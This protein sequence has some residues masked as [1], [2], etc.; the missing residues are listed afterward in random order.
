[1]KIDEK[2]AKTKECVNSN[3]TNM[4]LTCMG[5]Q[6]MAWKVIYHEDKDMGCC[7]KVYPNEEGYISILARNIQ[8]TR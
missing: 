3:N 5:S 2:E 1:M 7:G 4:S 6:C 8:E